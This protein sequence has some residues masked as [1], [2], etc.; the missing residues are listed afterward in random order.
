MAHAR[1]V[2]GSRVGAVPE[3]LDNGRCGL[4]AAPGNVPQFADAL[5]ALLTDRSLCE[6]LGRAAHER[7]KRFYD[8]A[9]VI[10]A[11]VQ[12]FNAARDAFARRRNG[13]SS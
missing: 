13:R 9:A 10:P 11:F 3:L 2:V 12:A 4:T 6:R 1:P 8:T 7:A 5:D